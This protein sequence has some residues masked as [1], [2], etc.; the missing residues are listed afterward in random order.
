MVDRM[1]LSHIAFVQV[2]ITSQQVKEGHLEQV[3]NNSMYM[4]YS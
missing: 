4:K 3:L 2:C 1:A